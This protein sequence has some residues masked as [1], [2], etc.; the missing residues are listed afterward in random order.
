LTPNPSPPRGEGGRNRDPAIRATQLTGTLGNSV[1]RAGAGPLAAASTPPRSG[2]PTPR[3]LFRRG[4]P[5]PH[6]PAPAPFAC[7]LALL[8]PPAAAASTALA[9]YISA[10][11]ACSSTSHSQ[12]AASRQSWAT[13]P[14]VVV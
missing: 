14:V 9:A 6:P 4:P 10:W 1:A 5:A 13:S 2:C 8:T 3:P 7:C 11:V 12:R